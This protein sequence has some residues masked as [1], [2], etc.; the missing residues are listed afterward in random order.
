MTTRSPLADVRVLD[1]SRFAPGGFCTLLLA[2]LGADVV[3]IEDP[4][5]G[6]GLRGMYRGGFDA[7]HIA[8]NRGKRSVALD[9]RDGGAAAVLERLVA[10]A[11]VVIDSH[12]PGQLDRFGL[13]YAAMSAANRAIVWCSITGFGDF[14]PNTDEPGHDL[15][16]LGYSGLLS[17]LSDSA[18]TPPGS[19]I[20]LPLA[21][22]MASTGILAALHEVQRTGQGTHLDVNMTDSAMW[23]R[24]EDVTRA[25]NAPGPAWGTF[26]ARNVY[27]CADGRHVT[28]TATEPK[29]WAAL[30]DAFGD[31][32]LAGHRLGVDEDAPVRSRL[33][34]LFATKPASDWLASP[35]LP[36]GVGPVNDAADLLTDP[37][38]TDRGSL[39]DLAGSDTQVLANPVRFNQASGAHASNATTPPP[40]LGA[41]TDEVLHEAGFVQ[42]EVDALRTA[43][44]IA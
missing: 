42:V 9:L 20:S 38:V 39:I 15:T 30:C 21:A 34:E 11:D 32:S 8:L 24:S 43:G 36:G 27:R 10:W 31:A 13:G 37:Q 6:D 5:S 35:G 33:E 29:A 7:A 40:D 2:D 19:V 26:A 16:Y 22:T 44:T 28:V 18:P 23:V 4:R 12:R 17:R 25:A 41:H 3:K 14:G 1:L